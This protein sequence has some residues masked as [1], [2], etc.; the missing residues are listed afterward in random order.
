M[1]AAPS[2]TALHVRPLRLWGVAAAWQLHVHVMAAVS[3][4][5]PHLL[6]ALLRGVDE[7]ESKHACLHMHGLRVGRAAARV[8]R[9]PP[10]PATGGSCCG[11]AAA[12]TSSVTTVQRASQGLSCCSMA[13]AAGCTVAACIAVACPCP[14]AACTALLHLQLRTAAALPCPVLLMP[15]MLCLR[16]GRCLGC[17]GINTR[18][19]CGARAVRAPQH[20]LCAPA[21]VSCR[22]VFARAR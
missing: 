13:T 16:R 18:L 8:R 17:A 12:R 15:A 4:G 2:A 3:A 21:A 1:A 20:Q 22:V 5:A 10:P 11:G 14:A 9:R 7:L 6:R 19:H